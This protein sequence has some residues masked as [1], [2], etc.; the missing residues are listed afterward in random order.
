MEDEFLKAYLNH[1]KEDLRQEATGLFIPETIDREQYIFIDQDEAT[2]LYLVEKGTVEAN[3]VHGD[4]KLY[5]F[6]FFYPGNIFGEPALYE[7]G[8]YSYS[9]V[10]REQTRLWRISW[11]DLQWLASQDPLFGLY[12]IRLLVRKIDGAYY[13]ERCI[14]GEKVEK[15]IACILLK[16]INERGITD[17]CGQI[18]DTALT[19]RDI[20]GLVGSTEETVS[21]IMSRL[22]KEE[23]ITIEDKLICVKKK[24][25][26]RAYFD[27]L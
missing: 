10:A 8:V 21:R 18:I 12:M 20:A 2:H 25:A 5:I 3:I 22:K 15:R 1:L 24:E 4:G 14:A 11:D 16:M 26:L 27:G 23:T 13:K 7:E 17:K 19:N 6:G 9:S